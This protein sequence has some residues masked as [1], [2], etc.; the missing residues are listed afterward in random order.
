MF[1]L[2][3]F[4]GSNQW[5]DCRLKSEFRLKELGIQFQGGFGAKHIVVQ[6]FD[7]ENQVISETDLY[8]EDTNEWQRFDLSDCVTAR[9]KLIFKQ[10]TD[11]FC[12]LVVYN[13]KLVSA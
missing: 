13:L 4:Q 10:F 11:L 2:D 7:R 3:W 1:T 8:A 9:I 5:I 12:R 6:Y